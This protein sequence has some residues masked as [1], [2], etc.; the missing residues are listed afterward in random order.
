MLEPRSLS[1][2]IEFPQ[3]QRFSCS[4]YVSVISA[5]LKLWFDKKGKKAGGTRWAKKWYIMTLKVRHFMTQISVQGGTKVVG[6]SQSYVAVS[7][8]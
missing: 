1:R 8:S 2:K 7:C 5:L 4:L 3:D 6:Q